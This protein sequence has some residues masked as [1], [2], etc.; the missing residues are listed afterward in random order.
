MY[1]FVNFDGNYGLYNSFEKN[2]KLNVPLLNFIQYL[3][4]PLNHI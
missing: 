4:N 2:D 3:N 1:I